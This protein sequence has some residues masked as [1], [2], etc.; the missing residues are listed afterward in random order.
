VA[1]GDRLLV[2]ERWLL[3]PAT[4]SFTALPYL[5]PGKPD[6]TPPTLA[7]DASGTRV[8]L[9]DGKS[10]RTGPLKGPLGPRVRLPRWPKRAASE[11][12]AEPAR[13]VP[14]W[15]SERHVV[16]RHARDY[17]DEGEARCQKLDV[18][19]RQWSS[20][21]CPEGELPTLWEIDPGPG[22]WVALL[23]S[24]EGH[25][26]VAFAHY[27]LQKG[28]RPAPGPKLDLYPSGPIEASFSKDGA[29]ILLATPCPLAE[30]P[31]RPCEDVP[32]DAPWRLYAWSIPQRALALVRAG[33]PADVTPSPKG[34]TLAWPEPR[35]VCV[36]PLAEP[37]KP[38]CFPVPTP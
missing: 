15:A 2:D 28:Q 38:S 37:G 9:F 11:E 36:A 32:D 14:F 16:V 10:L 4:G 25:P 20:A 8:A 24:G 5:P 23:S 22:N 19:T 33:L 29:R 13:D 18:D 21:P 34:D 31:E 35:R 17:P 26:N 3:T 6:P 1:G 30:R 7:V 12:E 27:D